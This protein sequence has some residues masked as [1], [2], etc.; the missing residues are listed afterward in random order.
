MKDYPF[1]ETSGATMPRIEKLNEYFYTA[2]VN[3]QFVS[4]IRRSSDA[5]CAFEQIQRD[6]VIALDD[7]GC[8]KI[9]SMVKVS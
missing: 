3:G 1:V 9:L 5:I 2:E 4:G 8:V 6:L 7:I